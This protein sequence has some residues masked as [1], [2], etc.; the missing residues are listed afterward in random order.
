MSVKTY[1]LLK[2]PFVTEKESLNDC[3]HTIKDISSLTDIISIN[4]TN[5][6]HHTV[7]E[8]LWKREQYR[9][10]WLWSV[11]EVLQQSKNLTNAVVKCD[12]VG[13]G[14]IRGA[15]NCGV[16]DRD[17]LDAIEQFSL[18]QKPNVFDALSCS[19]KNKW[20]DQLDVESLSFGSC[21]DFGRW[22]S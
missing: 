11:A 9:P 1:V 5:V 6:Q 22:N 12:V 18:S 3:L 21:V 14:S 4:P 19:C 20:L 15:H 16:C 2:P 10:A 8:Y 7:V 13:G 17:V